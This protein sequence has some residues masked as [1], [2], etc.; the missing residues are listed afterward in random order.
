MFYSPRDLQD[1]FVI[2]ACDGIWDVI[3]NEDVRD[4][5]LMKLANAQP[6]I[7]PDDLVK[8]NDEL[9][10]LCLERVNKMLEKSNS[11]VKCKHFFFL[12]YIG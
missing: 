9:L 2:L 4:F 7:N 6:K 3:K 1:K 11:F 8:M 10:N 12:Y 5:Y